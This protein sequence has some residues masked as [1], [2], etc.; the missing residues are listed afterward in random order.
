VTTRQLPDFGPAPT[1]QLWPE[2]ITASNSVRFQV[3]YLNRVNAEGLFHG[4]QCLKLGE[5]LLGLVEARSKGS[6]SG[7]TPMLFRFFVD[8]AI[9][10]RKQNEPLDRLPASIPEIILQYIRGTNPQDTATPDF[11]DNNL[12]VPAARCIGWC[13][14]EKRFIPGDVFRNRVVELIDMAGLKNKAD[15][16][17]KRLAANGVLVERDVGG[18]R[19][20]R[21]SLDPLAEYLAAIYWTD[22]LRDNRERWVRWLNQM[23]TI[24]PDFHKIK[25]FLVAL[26]DCINAYREE[27][28]IPSFEFPWANAFVDEQ[29]SWI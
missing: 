15:L 1:A 28:N 20:W 5:L 10:L 25:G 3:A 27:L 4:S 26:E 18:T 17:L 11:V 9:E 14:L 22:I 23:R 24:Q 19:R 21:F 12:L 6:V 7:V 29:A 8:Q 16:L 13:S 2:P